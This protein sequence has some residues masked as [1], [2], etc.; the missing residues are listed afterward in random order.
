MTRAQVSLHLVPERGEVR[1]LD[2]PS[3]IQPAP[4]LTPL[5]KRSPDAPGPLPANYGGPAN[6]RAFLSG[7][8]LR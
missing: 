2:G 3:T 7:T 4:L 5:P 6:L 8:Y 1:R